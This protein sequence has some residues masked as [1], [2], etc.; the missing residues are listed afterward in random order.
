[1]AAR[2]LNYYQER[3]VRGRA[4]FLVL[5]FL[6]LFA[7]CGLFAQEQPAP[8]GKDLQTESAFAEEIKQLE[9]AADKAA[10]VALFD[11]I[12]KKAAELKREPEPLISI[13][14]NRKPEVA[15]KELLEH[16]RDTAAARHASLITPLIVAAN[17]PGEPAKIAVAAV[18]AY[19]KDAV[20]LVIKLLA[21]DVASER[22]AAAAICCHRIG[23][24]EG[25]GKLV[26][27]LVATFKRN[28]ADL[29]STAIKALKRISLLDYDKPEQ[30]EAWLGKKTELQLATEIA[31]REFEQRRK[32][33][34][35]RAALE[36]KL[37]AITLKTMRDVESGNATAL[38]AR[39][40]LTEYLPVRL[41]A[42]KLLRELLK[43]SKD[44]VFKTIVD[45]L[46]GK[47][48]ETSELEDVRKQCAIGLAECGRA[49]LS[50]PHIDKALEANGISADLKLELVKGLNSSVA[51]ARVAALLRAEID[52][53]ETRGGAL[54]ETLISQ[55]RTVVDQKEDP[56]KA[57]I[58]AELSRLLDVVAAKLVADGLEAPARKRYVDLAVRACDTLVHIARQR[59][60]DVSACVDSLIKISLTENGA[61]SAA[62]TALR[63]ALSVP[64]TRTTL[65]DKLTTPPESEQL[66]GL[67]VKLMTNG[68]DPMLVKL[69]G[70][71]E[72]LAFSPEPLADLRQRLLD[73]ASSSEAQPPT[74]AD[75]RKTLREALRA[76]LA[77]LYTTQE[78]HVAL[79]T[80]LLDAEYGGN[81][82]LGYMMVLKTDRVAI[83]TSAMQPMVDKRPIKLAQL[84]IRLDQ[85][86]TPAERDSQDYKS[87]RGGLNTAVRAAF[88][89][90]VSKALSAPLDDEGRKELTGLATGPLRDQ[91][92]PTAVAELDKKPA[93][94][95]E[96]DTVSEILLSS[97]RA[98]HPDKYETVSLKGLNQ[99]DFKRA[100]ADLVT[101]LKND[102]YAV[103]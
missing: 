77:V 35:E 87:F 86:L 33:E 60:V 80:E 51:G 23:G 57:E 16:L 85:S 58:L 45:A 27:K 70:L 100:L 90:R 56:H 32:A 28:E 55:V 67:Y 18:Q 40:S 98:A 89:D 68:D 11:A 75:S 52:V 79:L 81:D 30:W 1:V 53:V 64:A 24:A 12:L 95:A 103:P 19:G 99:E 5:A 29:T 41:E 88:S 4:P 61:A 72:G 25:T 74:S 14:Q 94:S 91:F 20:P 46:G 97:L 73:R 69:I 10:R 7:T 2:I 43:T 63:E 22:L 36:A 92:V 50:F 47:L 71:Y 8:D 9:A 54:L 66:A 38:I 31:D 17:D 101:R 83:L 84:V 93:P 37:V 15:Y 13:L 102:G 49:E 48:N 82:A 78:D 34:A 65:T 44:D 42:V 76:L 62:L 6:G 59:G 3:I 21:S 96:R 39:M 26:P